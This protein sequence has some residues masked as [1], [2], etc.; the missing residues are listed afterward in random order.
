MEI[1]KR[2]INN[3]LL[4]NF[5]TLF[6]A[7][8]LAQIITI[9]SSPLLTRIYSS[10][11]FGFYSF[12]ISVCSLLIVFT[13][14]R[15]EFAINAVKEDKESKL[16]FLLVILLSIFVATTIFVIEQTFNELIINIF[17]LKSNSSLLFLIPLTLLVMGIMQGLNY[18]LNK[19]KEFNLISKGKILQ[20]SL[21]NGNSIFLGLTGFTS[22]GL[23][24]SNFLGLI[25]SII[26]QMFSKRLFNLFVL[27]KQTLNETIQVAKRYYHYPMFNSTS[28][29][30]DSLAL[31]A[32]V[33]VLMR[34]FSESIVG[35]YSLTLRV[36]GIPITLVSSSLSQVFLSEIADLHRQGQPYG[37]ILKRLLK[38]L[39]IIGSIPLIFLVMAGPLI[40]SYVF[41]EEWKMSGE[42]SKILAFGYYAKF[43]VSPLSVVFFVSQKVKLLSYIQGSRAITTLIVLLISAQFSDIF[44]VVVSYVIHEILF[45]LLYLWVIFKV[46]KY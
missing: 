14:G 27:N 8:L 40:F 31:Q 3:K 36:V 17:N 35:F 41:G 6:S 18:Y 44:I 39:L 37:H 1:S 45:Y 4:K 10:D 30:L 43:V 11:E 38:I 15:Y 21:T 23:I 42:L 7:T 34:F 9:A 46:S 33:F 28:A 16:L 2:I 24:L 22:F 29:F 26:Y 25:M 13:T 12:Y 20:S 19:Y 5:G 32:P